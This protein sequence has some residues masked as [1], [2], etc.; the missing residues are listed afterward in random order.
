ME[1]KGMMG[2]IADKASWKDITKGKLSEWLDEYKKAT[3]VL[4]TFGFTVGKVSLG[5]GVG[6]LP[7]MH[8]SMSASIDNIR[9]EKLRKMIEEHKAEAL[10]VSLLN[11][12]IV[13]RWIWEHV[14]LKLKSVT[15]HVTLGV[16]P[17]R[18]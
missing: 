16:T 8:T 6:M 5:T 4:E 9:E 2:K 7:E 10:L 12:L 3:A 11:A 1:I 14:E 13:T 17:K 18:T 15:P